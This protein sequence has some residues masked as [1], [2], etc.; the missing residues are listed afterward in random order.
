MSV[1][2]PAPASSKG[3]LS[4]INVNKREE[5]IKP[6]AIASALTFH[7]NARPYFL[8]ASPKPCH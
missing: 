2:G 3:K 7:Y 8:L 5:V 6:V 1:R 4:E